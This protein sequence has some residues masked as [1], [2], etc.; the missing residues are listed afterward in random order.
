[1]LKTFLQ[2]LKGNEI[3]RKIVEKISKQIFWQEIERKRWNIL[4]EFFET[5]FRDTIEWKLKEIIDCW[6]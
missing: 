6:S 1:M 5:K 3:E 2:K 4:K